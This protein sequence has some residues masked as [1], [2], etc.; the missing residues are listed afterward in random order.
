MVI[1]KNG[2]EE[3]LREGVSA[4]DLLNDVKLEVSEFFIFLNFWEQSL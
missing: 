2:D 4:S 3:V 1:K